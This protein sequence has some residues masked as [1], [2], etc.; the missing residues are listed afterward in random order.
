[1]SYVPIV[2]GI[3]PYYGRAECHE[4]EVCYVCGDK[5]MRLDA[6]DD[7]PG[8]HN[9]AQKEFTKDGLHWKAYKWRLMDGMSEWEYT[10]L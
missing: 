8:K 2:L 5:R 9:S 7:R 6:L 3:K 1:M 4:L 10:N